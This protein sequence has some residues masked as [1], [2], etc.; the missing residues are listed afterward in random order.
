MGT[1]GGATGT[2]RWPVR[3]PYPPPSTGQVASP[4]PSTA[5]RRR[6][7]VDDHSGRAATQLPPFD[8]K[9]LSGTRLWSPHPHTAS[10]PSR[11][12][13]AGYVADSVTSSAS[14]RKRVGGAPPPPLPTTYP[15]PNAPRKPA[16]RPP[17][18]RPVRD[19]D[20]PEAGEGGSRKPSAHGRNRSAGPPTPSAPSNRWTPRATRVRDHALRG[21]PIAPV[22]EPGSPPH[23]GPCPHAE[24]TPGRAALVWPRGPR[25]SFCPSSGPQRGRPHSPMSLTGVGQA[26]AEGF[27]GAAGAAPVS[28]A[29]GVV[30]G[31]R[32]AR[33]SRPRPETC[34]G[35]RS[36]RRSPCLPGRGSVVRACTRESRGAGRARPPRPHSS[37][38]PD[39]PPR[40]RA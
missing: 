30:T 32:C 3:R 35:Y 31:F 27:G 39:V 25:I 34:R 2:R 10:T 14:A 36:P 22:R 15:R 29:G 28:G 17:P 21:V 6:L 40:V 23:A 4:P 5:R 24:H 13:R 12:R 38:T 26:E 9:R 33:A 19:T 7:P 11:P 20:G 18:A 1:S 16:L 8:S 37:R